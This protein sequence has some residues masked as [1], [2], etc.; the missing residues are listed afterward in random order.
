ME[1]IFKKVWFALFVS[2]LLV[3]SICLSYFFHAVMGWYAPSDLALKPGDYKSIY[4][5]VTII[6][7]HGNLEHLFFNVIPLFVLTFLLVFFYLKISIQAILFIITFG[8]LG[9]F[10]FAESG[11]HIGASGLVFGLITFL[12]ISGFIRLNRGLIVIS[13]LVVFLYGSTL[14]GVMPGDP[15]ISWEGHLF[16]VIAG[17]LA[18]IIW[19]KSGP[20]QNIKKIGFRRK[21]DEDD[22]YM[23]FNS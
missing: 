5:I 9:L 10:M 13:L 18:S 16:G 2:T 15:Q 21:T 4:G 1:L 12:I 22:E 14:W 17:F 20:K 6:L 8:G 23:A 19:R 7:V 3:S 11:V